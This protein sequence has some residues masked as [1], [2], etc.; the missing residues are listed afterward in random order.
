VAE[1]AAAS[2]APGI[3]VGFNLATTGSIKYGPNRHSY[4]VEETRWVTMTGG[5]PHVALMVY[6]FTQRR[7]WSWL[8]GGWVW[9]EFRMEERRKGRGEG[10]GGE[11]RRGGE[12][13]KVYVQSVNVRRETE[14]AQVHLFLN[15]RD[16][17]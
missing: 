3:S 15:R 14:K 7:I 17:T 1:V 13:M 10:G 8:G 6:M 5:I 2:A 16:L 9:D 4:N 11:R 12:K